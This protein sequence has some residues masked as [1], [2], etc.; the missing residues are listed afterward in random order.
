MNFFK[1]LEYQNKEEL[2]VLFR[3][4]NLL[5]IHIR[6]ISLVYLPSFTF[7]GYTFCIKRY[8]HCFL[9]LF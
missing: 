3:G 8:K 6:R 2:A 5:K 7:M 9:F 1:M 4:F